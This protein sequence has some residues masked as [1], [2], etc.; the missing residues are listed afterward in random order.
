MAVIH[1]IFK[2]IVLIEAFDETHSQMVT[3]RKSYGG[4]QWLDG[5]K[6]TKN[7]KTNSDGKIELFIG[8]L[9]SMIKVEE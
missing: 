3:E 2:I 5:M 7:F 4:D 8:D 6:F 9:D 1:F